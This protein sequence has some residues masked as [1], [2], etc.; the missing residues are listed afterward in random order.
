MPATLEQL[1][2]R[3]AVVEQEVARL[4]ERLEQAQAA[5]AGHTAPLPN[6]A[7][8]ATISGVAARVFAAL[9]ITGRPI[10]AEKVQEMI[11]ACGVKPEDNEFSRGILKMREE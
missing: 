11:A 3:L 10:G 9:G 5:R 1:E 6:A 4:R 2:A 8:Q 7:D